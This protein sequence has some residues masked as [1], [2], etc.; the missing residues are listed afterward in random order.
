MLSMNYCLSCLS[1]L[2]AGIVACANMA[3]LLRFSMAMVYILKQSEAWG[4]SKSRVCDIEERAWASDPLCLQ[5]VIRP[6][7]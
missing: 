5:C 2:S 6:E 1:L 3:R 4:W 7:F